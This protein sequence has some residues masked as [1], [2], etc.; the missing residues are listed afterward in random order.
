MGVSVVGTHVDI[1]VEIC[2]GKQ[3]TLLSMLLLGVLQMSA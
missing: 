2:F 3:T 1:D